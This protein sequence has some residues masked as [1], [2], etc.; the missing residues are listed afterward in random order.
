MRSHGAEHQL[1]LVGV[2]LVVGDDADR[3]RDEP[4]HPIGDEERDDHAHDEG[5]RREHETLPQ[6]DQVLAE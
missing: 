3:L 2:A 1:H 4:D 6:L 5:D